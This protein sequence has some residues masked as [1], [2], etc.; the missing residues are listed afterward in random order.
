[1]KKKNVKICVLRLY[2]YHFIAIV[3]I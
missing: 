2:Q 1:M 3:V